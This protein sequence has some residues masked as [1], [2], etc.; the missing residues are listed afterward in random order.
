MT[1][2]SAF[3]R[4]LGGDPDPIELDH[5]A[6]SLDALRR[7]CREADADQAGR[8]STRKAVGE[9]RHFGGTALVA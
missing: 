5:L 3:D 9:R 2:S 6:A 1:P 8:R 4:S 7:T